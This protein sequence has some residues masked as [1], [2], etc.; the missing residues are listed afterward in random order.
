M[1]K[2]EKNHLF[3]LF[4]EERVKNTFHMFDAVYKHIDNVIA[5]KGTGLIVS[6]MP[7]SWRSNWVL[8]EHCHGTVTL[9]ETG[10]L[11][12]YT[13]IGQE[14]KPLEYFNEE[15]VVRYHDLDKLVPIGGMVIKSNMFMDLMGRYELQVIL[16]FDD[17]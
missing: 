2:Y 14:G 6:K 1:S 13:C 9:Y 3:N 7:N 10:L 16:G 17:E 15:S 12:N 11:L 4:Q 8:N 5:S